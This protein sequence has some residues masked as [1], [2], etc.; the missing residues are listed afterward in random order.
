MRLLAAYVVIVF[1]VGF[2]GVELGFEFDKLMPTLA[3]PIGLAIFFGVLIAGWPLAVYVTE[4]WL[5]SEQP[6]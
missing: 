3:V 5:L 1:V 2:F 4:R 6:K